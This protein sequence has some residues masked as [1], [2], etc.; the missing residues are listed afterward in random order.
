MTAE[1]L[2]KTLSKDELLS[3]AFALAYQMIYVKRAAK[4]E[5]VPKT[6]LDPVYYE[7]CDDAWD[8]VCYPTHSS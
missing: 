2:A 7:L 5:P 8:L 4:G 1:E 3:N 6:G